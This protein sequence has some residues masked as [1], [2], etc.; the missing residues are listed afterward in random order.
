MKKRIAGIILTLVY[1]FIC[2]CIAADANTSS[3]RTW[4]FRDFTFPSLEQGYTT[5]SVTFNGL[6]LNSGLFVHNGKG[7]VK[8]L[9][10]EG[11]IY[12]K[13]NGSRN[14]GFMKFSVNGSTDIHILGKSKSDTEDRNLTFYTTADGR[15]YDLK[16]THVTDDYIYKYRGAAGDVYLY[17][18][19]GGVRIYSITAK[20]YNAGEYAEL[21][22][23]TKRI[24]D[25]EDYTEYSG[26]ITENISFN[27]MEIK[28]TAENPVIID[29]QN[30]DKEPYGYLKH[31]Y[32]NLAGR[33]QYGYRYITFPVNKN[34]DIYI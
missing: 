14:D 29:T 15:T 5:D 16:M 27:D 30:S 9:Y 1:A 13:A 22:E 7:K 4:C 21:G 33:L 10:F 28:A 8:N 31:R 2:M 32:V 18:A 12:T 25:F 24:W 11:S 6:T 3:E 26:S 23:G 19:G 17:T 34:S 20:D